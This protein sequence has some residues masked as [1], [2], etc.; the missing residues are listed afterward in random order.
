MFEK[1]KQLKIKLEELNK[2]LADPNIYADQ[3]H[4]QKVAKEHADLVPIIEKYEEYLK[5]E[6][7]MNDAEEM[8]KMDNCEV[9]AVNSPDDVLKYLGL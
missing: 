1:L 7:D 5:V 3:K 2:E 8:R 9:I 4:Y 6:R